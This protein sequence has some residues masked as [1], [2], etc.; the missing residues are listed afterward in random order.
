MQASIDSG[1]PIEELVSDYYIT[2]EQAKETLIA[3]LSQKYDLT[4]IRCFARKG[5]YSA[6]IDQ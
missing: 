5:G 1:V 4:H 6:E 3:T 2:E